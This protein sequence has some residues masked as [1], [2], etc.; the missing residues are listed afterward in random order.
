M[1]QIIDFIVA[2]PVLVLVFAF[3]LLGL[4]I[5]ESRKGGQSL[6]PQQATQLVNG[7]NGVLVDIRKKDEFK[8]GHIAGAVN[9]EYANFSNK[10]S[11]LEKH[12]DKPIIVVCKT[13]TTAGAAGAILRKS[14]FT[15]VNKLSGGILEWQAQKLPLVKK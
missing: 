5:T 10:L 4:L 11:E 9:I 7:Q 6:S 2:N 14:G 12:K 3:F 13:G 15:Q 8:A 1:E